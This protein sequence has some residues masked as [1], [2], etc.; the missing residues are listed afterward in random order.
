MRC[1]QQNI[2]YTT[3]YNHDFFWG[4]V[5]RPPC[6]TIPTPPAPFLP[7][8]KKVPKLPIEHI[9]CSCFRFLKLQTKRFNTQK[10]P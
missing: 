2:Q 7:V 3:N 9:L 5:L 6:N 1:E 4:E 10:R 8:P